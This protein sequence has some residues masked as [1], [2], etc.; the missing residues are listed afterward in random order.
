MKPKTKLQKLVYK[1]SLELN[2]LS[3]YQK[4]KAIQKISPH[5]AKLNSKN[6]YVC[7]DCGHKWTAKPAKKIQCP[8][9]HI[10][11]DVST[12]R[13][14]NRKESAY[15]AVVTK[16]NG[17]QVVRMFYLTTYL[18]RTKPADHVIL[19]VFQHWIRPDGKIT[20]IS[21]A[22]R[23]FGLYVDSWDFYSD[24]EIRNENVAHTVSPYMVIGKSSV[25]PELKRNGFNGNYHNCDPKSLFQSLLTDNKV[26]T[27]WK[28]KQYKLV[29]DYIY[30]THFFT[31]YWS[32][33]KIAIRHNYIIKD[34]DIWYDLLDALQNC[35]QDI[36]NPRF[37]CPEYLM[38]AH[39]F[40]VN[41]KQ[42]KQ[43][44]EAERRNRERYQNEVQ[45]YFA[46]QQKVV[47]D[48][49]NYKKSK[50]RF[51]NIT[52][53]QDNIEIKPLV[54][55]MEFLEEGHK[56]HH[57][58]FTNQYY[59]RDDVLILHALKDGVSIATIELSLL[60]YQ[61]IQ[62]RGV[63][64]QIPPHNKQIR[65]LIQNN[66]KKIIMASQKQTA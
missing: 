1:Y 3:E 62:C 45:R 61:I 53:K 29:E 23:W 21:R 56:M 26:E 58:V 50:S 36:K 32:S 35:G 10:D 60:N 11:L 65:D 12:E 54:S 47:E 28:M 40:W 7:L 51:F 19:E 46:N 9:C 27:A 48:E 39:D 31:K 33:I 25:I 30:R 66:I 13:K 38:K 49:E 34:T 17:F 8:H 57:C 42:I 64:N 4:N 24:L 2:P 5:I 55:I 41:K 63:C 37:I 52:L 14:W 59:K 22:R 16:H 44:K 43:A 15:F 6:E 18:S 20:I